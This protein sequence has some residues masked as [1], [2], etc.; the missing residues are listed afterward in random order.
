MDFAAQLRVL[1][2]AHGDPAKLALAAVDL[3]Y[4]SLPDTERALLKE[5]LAAAAIPHWCDEAL[6]AAL[7]GIS[8]EASTARLVRLRGLNV[9]EPFPARGLNAVNVHEAARL[10]LRKAMAEEA[11]ERFRALSGRAAATFADD[12]SP[13]GRIEWLYH[14]L[15]ADP[16]RGAAE[17][18][19]LDR[20][21]SSAARPEDR[22]AL[23][24][25]LAELEA[26]G[27]VAGRARVEVLLCVAESRSSRGETAQLQSN[28]SVALAL[29]KQC[30]H[31]SGEAR[32]NSLVGDVFQAQGKLAEAQAAFGEYLRISRALAELHPGSAGWQRDLAVA[33]SRVGDVLQ[34]QGKLAEAQAAFGE[35]LR[36][37][38]GLAELDPG[39]AGWQRDL[40]LAHSWVGGVL[41]A[42]GKL[43]EA[44]AAFGEDL[45]ISRGLAELDPGN[46]GWQR[47]L[48]VAHSRVGDVLQAQG[49]LAEAHAAFEA[50][51]QISRRL[52]QLDPSNAEWQRGLAVAHSKV[53][54]VLQAQGKLAEAQAA[55]GEN[56]R[57]SRGL[58]ELDPGNA[59]WQRELAV[60]HSTVGDV[61]Q[62]QGKLAE[63]QAAFAEGLKIFRA[64]TE[65]DPGNAG[66]QRDLAVACVKVARAEQELGRMTSAVAHFAEAQRVYAALVK[67]APG[68]V[69][70]VKEQGWVEEELAEARRLA[71]A[72]GDSESPGTAGA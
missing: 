42:Q 48:A 23:A 47:D 21:W 17:C 5:T 58:A 50:R 64:L 53:G 69:E 39:N 37:Y 66:W 52:A 32:A 54:D 9:V 40:A 22:Y 55:F 61:L 71:A 33:H 20:K 68:F 6:L 62:A 35:C 27:L 7:L 11:G 14:L 24:L 63:A 44:Q 1:Q 67:A 38:R 41:Q 3:A 31:A 19:A 51:M 30:G 25:V 49:K 26:S 16:E 18:E 10:A 36:I 28:A 60:A 4:P 15:C 72:Q 2:A 43:A 59:G 34:A 12:F 29:A 65:L 56:L 8:V 70:W 57:I 13:T 46:A 45:R